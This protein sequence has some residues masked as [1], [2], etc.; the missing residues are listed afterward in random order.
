MFEWELSPQARAPRR[1]AGAA[2]PTLDGPG[3]GADA[4]V[5]LGRGRI[6]GSG[7]QAPNMLANLVERGCV[8]LQSE[9]ATGTEDMAERY[10]VFGVIR[11]TLSKND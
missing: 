3:G 6:V 7:T 8:V 5:E 1:W 9:S 10:H 2:A 4:A 11:T